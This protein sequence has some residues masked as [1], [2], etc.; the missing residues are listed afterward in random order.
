MTGHLCVETIGDRGH[1]ALLLLG[2]ATW[3]MDWWDDEL[4]RR[5]A[6][7]GRLVI[8]YDSRDTGRSTS[9]P[10]GA[11]GYGSADL[12]ADAGPEPDWTDRDSVI[13]YL[14]EGD[15]PY[16]EPGNFDEPRLRALAGRV[17]DSTTDMAASMISQ[18]VLE[19]GGATGLRLSSRLG[20]LQTLV[21]HGT[22]DPLF[23]I[24]HGRAGRQ[25]TPEPSCALPTRRQRSVSPYS[26]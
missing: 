20:D 23:P 9:Y 13:N 7:R 22:A 24:P 2:A 1:P 16:A 8:R 6:D 21:L 3:S 14:V 5:L 11:P 12:V 4:C 18:F 25:G 19:Y 26:P 17:F 15:R 10:P